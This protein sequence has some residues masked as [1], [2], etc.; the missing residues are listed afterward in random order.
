MSD[1][2]QIGKE[3]VKGLK[4]ETEYA[5]LVGVITKQY[6]EEQATEHLDELE[7][8]AKTAGAV[9]KKRVTQ[10]LQHPDVRT[11]VER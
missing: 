5:V 1:N 7:F 8:L 3:R 9:I 10:K 4:K 2:W 11:F 6:T